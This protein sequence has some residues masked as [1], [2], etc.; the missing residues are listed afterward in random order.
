MAVQIS[1]GSA[2]TRGQWT[3]TRRPQVA[4]I[5]LQGG[6]WPEGPSHPLI[7]PLLGQV[8]KTLLC[9]AKPTALVDRYKIAVRRRHLAWFIDRPAVVIGA[10]QPGTPAPVIWLDQASRLPVRLR[11]SNVEITL[12]GWD[13]P[14]TLRRCPQFAQIRR[15]DRVITTRVLGPSQ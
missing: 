4:R 12:N 10:D 13:S 8:L 1:D 11:L 9:E 14:A 15:G 7:D 5:T 6:V 2:R 3:F